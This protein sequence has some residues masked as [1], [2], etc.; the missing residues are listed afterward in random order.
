MSLRWVRH[1]KAISSE[2]SESPFIFTPKVENNSFLD[3]SH[4]FLDLCHN[5]F[6]DGETLAFM[7]NEL[8]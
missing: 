1:D 6:D 4:F 2:L 7:G 5:G 8:K 3:E